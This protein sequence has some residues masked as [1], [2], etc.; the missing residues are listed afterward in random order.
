MTG[1][2]PLDPRRPLIVTKRQG[3]TR[4]IPASKWWIDRNTP[5][6]EDADIYERMPHNGNRLINRK[7]MVGQEE[8]KP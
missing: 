2:T 1:Y 7:T 4:V 3:G 6:G 8:I 5:V